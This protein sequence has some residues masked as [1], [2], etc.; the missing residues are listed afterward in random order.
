MFFQFTFIHSLIRSSL[1]IA[2]ICVLPIDRA[3]SAGSELPSLG[4][5]SS[6]NI[7]REQSLGRTVYERL[8]ER[9]LIET[10]PLLDRYINDIGFRLLAGIDSRVREYRFFIV[11][12]DAVNAFAVPGGYI[13][14]NRGLINRAQTQ[15]QLASVIAHEI[16][17]VRLRHG[18]DMM[19]KGR[20]LSNAAI[21]ATLAG[22]LLG[23]VDSQVGAAVALG[24][25]AGSQ[26]S[27]INFTRENEYEADR[28]G[29]ELMKNA[30]FD[31]QGTVEFFEII[32]SLTGG[33]GGIE[34][35]RT[36]PLGSNRIAEAAA[37][38]AEGGRRKQQVDDYQL[39]KD[40]LLY[41]GSDHLPDQGS[42]YLRGLASMQ[43]GDYPR[44]DARLS[45][46]YRSDSENIWYGIAYAENLEMLNR[47][48]EAEHVYRHLLD[49]FPGDYAISMRLL[50]LYK[51]REQGQKA[52]EIARDLEIRFP[53]DQQ[54]YF[55]LS[56][57][58]AI[59]GKP[60]LRLM[61]QAEYHRITGNY[62]QAIRLYDEILQSRNVDVATEFK[63]REKRLILLEN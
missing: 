35:L 49:I 6:I 11:R 26:Q 27:M 24:G 10:Q 1:L 38:A 29:I 61:A 50:E 17:H 63:A 53:N 39:F 20:D 42:P 54:V 18:L 48:D 19:E 31:P 51:S 33:T 46:L 60:A 59:L 47:K 15:H 4:E 41:V 57:V 21:L 37:R 2:L 5:D 58:Y 40:Y 7:E 45:E 14:I 13:G 36:H 62:K 3:Y 34:Y 8:L 32:T 9:G 30:G 16:A 22:L 55:E 44:A 12:D 43:S 56:E 23:T 25:A 28:F 52:L